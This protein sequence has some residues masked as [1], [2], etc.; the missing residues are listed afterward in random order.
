MLCSRATVCESW[1]DLRNDLETASR[2][3]NNKREVWAE[4][5]AS[6]NILTPAT[7]WGEFTVN[8]SHAGTDNYIIILHHYRVNMQS[9]EK[10]FIY[11]FDYISLHAKNL[12]FETGCMVKHFRWWHPKA[13][14][15]IQKSP[16]YCVR[17]FPD[18]AEKPQKLCRQN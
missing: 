17:F 6:V 2:P 12:L 1:P 5:G 16:P 18:M 8:H 14:V 9:D 3:C 13:Q 15:C 11:I 4:G 10:K 7:F